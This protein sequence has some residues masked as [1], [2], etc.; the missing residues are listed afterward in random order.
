MKMIKSN[1]IMASLIAGSFLV[2]SCNNTPAEQSEAMND[3]VEKIEDKV[4]DAKVDNDWERE[5]ADVMEDFRELQTK[6]DNKLA[7]VNED[8]AK[9]DLK[10]EV[11]AEKEA[12]KAE[13]IREQE[14]VATKMKNV[15]GATTDNWENTKADVENSR[16]EMDSW[17]EKQKENV[18]V[19][20]DADKDNDGH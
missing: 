3:K 15:E 19:K 18:D 12:M 1:L 16:R 2:V 11:R 13:L 10:A 5:R 4:Q 8:L 7:E 9:K 20:T 17:W 6:I 14:L